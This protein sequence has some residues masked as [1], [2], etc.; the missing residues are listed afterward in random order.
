MIFS[1]IGSFILSGVFSLTLSA[2]GVTA[3]MTVF[4]A[5]S[6]SPTA[7]TIPTVSSPQLVL[8][9]QAGVT[10]WLRLIAQ[11]RTGID[12][13]AYLVDNPAIAQ[14]LRQAGSRG[15]PIQVLL[16]PNPYGATDWVP[17]ERAL[18]ATIPHILVRQPPSRFIGPYTFD[19]A[20]YLVINPGTPSVQA[21]LGSA[22]F[23]V[24]AVNGTNLEA[25]VL[26]SGDPAQ[27][28]AGVFHAD[29]TDHPAGS[30]PRRTLILSPGSQRAITTL[31]RTSGPIALSAEELGNDRALDQAI[32][33]DGSRVHLL[34][35]A[36]LSAGTRRRAQMLTQ[37]GV[38]VRTLTHPVIH[39]KVLITTTRAFVGS[40]N[41]SYVSLTRN[42]EMGCLVQGSIRTSLVHWFTHYWTQAQ[43]L[44]ASPFVVKGTAQFA[45]LTP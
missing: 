26:V 28:A 21:L 18:L 11:A 35:A 37:A 38:Q 15:V 43:P 41:L 17:Q 7:F 30:G 29:W 22:N 4:A 25:D 42:R 5:F 3:P 32:A 31:L 13:N 24:S 40:E 2:C 1:Q 14:A 20:K 27:A 10:P 39:A 45:S 16:A 12:V 33:H 6:P 9:P 19:H 44:A 34:L 8:E 36:P 23:T